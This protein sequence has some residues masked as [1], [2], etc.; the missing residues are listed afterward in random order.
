MF[1]HSLYHVPH[2]RQ[3]MFSEK[4]FE[5]KKERKEPKVSLLTL[6]CLCEKSLS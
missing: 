4:V 6:F 1:H 5:I 2:V 3:E